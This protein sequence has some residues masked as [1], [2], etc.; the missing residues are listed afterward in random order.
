[1]LETLIRGLTWATWE[2][3]M[4]TFLSG[5]APP[6]A[7]CLKWKSYSACISELLI[8]CLKRESD[9]KDSSGEKRRTHDHMVATQLSFKVKM[10]SPYW[11]NGFILS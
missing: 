8:L 6:A 11:K 4:I 3:E 10:C 7:W 1:M 2:V 9:F 5:F